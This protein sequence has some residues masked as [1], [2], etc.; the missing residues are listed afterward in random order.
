MSDKEEAVYPTLGT[1][2][3]KS[4]AMQVEHGTKKGA[5]KEGRRQDQNVK[6]PACSMTTGNCLHL[7]HY[8]APF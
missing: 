2:W 8:K 1:K 4:K 7:V 3:L 5:G 6:D